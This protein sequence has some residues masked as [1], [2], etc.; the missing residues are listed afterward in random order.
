M[1]P[2]SPPRTGRPLKP[3]TLK[4][5]Q[6]VRNDLPAE[7]MA[8]SAEGVDL[9]A[10]ANVDMDD[11]G[12][13]SRRGGYSLTV[14]GSD[15][16]SLFATA[17][18]RTVLVIDG[19]ELKRVTDNGATVATI[20]SGLAAG[21]RMSYWEHQGRV[22]HCNGVNSGVYEAGNVRN[23]GVRRP[24][25][26]AVAATGGA[27]PAG[28]YAVALTFVCADGSESGAGPGSDITLDAPGGIAVNVV[29][30]TN[31]RVTHV[32]VYCT[33]AD[34]GAFYRAGSVA[35]A[36]QVFTIAGQRILQSPLIT[37][38][39]DKPPVGHLVA[40]YRGRAYLAVG[41]LLHWS[42]PYGLEIFKPTDHLRLGST[43]RMIAPSTDGLYLSTDEGT[44]W[45]AGTDPDKFTLLRVGDPAVPGSVTYAKSSLVGELA[46]NALVP[47][48]LAGEGVCI[49]AAGGQLSVVN[50]KWRADDAA[51]GAG[52][53]REAGN[54][55]QYLVSLGA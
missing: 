46:G 37:Q 42:S 29:A 16:H 54:T 38:H 41:D 12:G 40:I 50:K 52:L 36:A 33:T 7:G 30:S 24:A 5:F 48:W 13:L 2:I 10:G 31:P 17:D 34:G 9:V 18:G 51:S 20:G 14:A 1:A 15:M 39:F 27:L 21:A 44:F 23:W 35:N 49:G 55:Y 25:D 4:A 26:P 43:L 19:T 11:R 8:L 45:A 53:I 22:Y 6:G 32:N 47:V 3:L 28:R